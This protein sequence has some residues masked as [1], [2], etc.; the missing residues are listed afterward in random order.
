VTW[1]LLILLAGQPLTPVYGFRAKAACGYAIA[2]LQQFVRPDELIV[3][4]CL[5]TDLVRF[6]SL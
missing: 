5:P 4:A 3:L 2:S 1:T 6:V